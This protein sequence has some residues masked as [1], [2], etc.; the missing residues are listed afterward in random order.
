MLLI[1]LLGGALR[2]YGINW[3]QNSHYHPDERYI[4]MVTSDIR[5]PQ[6]INEF[7]DP[8]RSPMNPYWIARENRERAFAYGT[9]PVYMTRFV[10]YWVGVFVDKWWEGYDG[11]TLVGR[12]LSGLLDTAAIF[13]VFLLG[14]RI[15]NR[16]VGL[17]G[18][19]FYALTVL[20]IQHSHF[21]TTDITLNF[22]VLLTLL[23]AYNTSQNGSNSNT[24]MMGAAAGMAF[25]SKFSALPIL[26][27]LPMAA[28]LYERKKIT[29][30]NP[31][32]VTL[33][34]QFAYLNWGS[35]IS[36]LILAFGGFVLAY[37]I[38]APY[39]FL[40][41][42]GLM[43]NV[44]EQDKIVIRA[45]ADLPYTRQ[46]YETTP[47][48]YPIEQMLRWSMGVPLGVTALIGFVMCVVYALGRG[49]HSG[50]TSAG[51]ILMLSWM[52]PYFIITGRAYAKF[53]RYNLPLLPLFAI[54][55]AA[56]LITLGQ[57]LDKKYRAKAAPVAEPESAPIGEVTPAL[58][59][60]T[61]PASA[62]APPTAPKPRRHPMQYVAPALTAIVVVATAWWA[63]AFASIYSAP[64][65]ANQASK[66]INDNV[67]KNA[68]I[69]K[70]HWEEGIA[71][72]HG[73]QLPPAV[74]ELNLYDDDGPNK[75]ASL[76]NSLTRG[77]YIVFFSSR[78]YGTIPRIPDRYP[79]TKR[80][81]EML[82][83]G[84]LG[85][86]LV[87]F[88]E[89]FPSFFGVTMF[90]DTFARPGLPM[91]APLKAHRPTPFEINGGFADESFSAYDH[92]LVMVFKKTKPITPQMVTDWFGPYALKQPW[93]R[94]LAQIKR[95]PL[96]T[97]T[98]REL[99]MAGGTFSDLFDANSLAN[100]MPLLMWWLLLQVFSLSTLPI[101][102]H[103]A[104]GLPDRAYIFARV[105]GWL[106]V[107]W[108]IWFPVSFGVFNYTRPVALAALLLW[109]G[110]GALVFART[111]HHLLAWL[112]A[113][114][115][116]VALQEIVFSVGFLAFVWIRMNNPD[117]WHPARGGEKPMDFAYLLAAIKTST[118]PPYDPWFAGGF[119]NYY[120]YGQY[121]VGMMVKITGILPEV[122]YNL[123]VPMLFAMCL[124]GAWSL[125]YNLIASLRRDI[126]T[127]PNFQAPIVDRAAAWAGTLAA[128]LLAVFGNV[129]G[130]MRFFKRLVFIGGSPIPEQSYNAMSWGE[131]MGRFALGIYKAITEGQKALQIPTDWF[132][133]STRI[134][135]GSGSIQEFPYFTFLYADLH[136]HMIALPVSLL[137]LCWALILMARLGAN[138]S[139]NTPDADAAAENSQPPTLRQRLA[140]WLNELRAQA[141][142]LPLILLSGITLGSVWAINS[143]DFPIA[144]VIILGAAI[145]GWLHT[146]RQ[147]SQFIWAMLI[148]AAIVAWGYVAYLPFH[149]SFVQGYTGLETHQ[150][151]SP[152]LGW[153]TVDGVFLFI[154]VTWLLVWLIGRLRQNNTVTS[155]VAELN[156]LS[157]SP[158]LGI[159]SGSAVRVNVKSPKLRNASRA[160]ALLMANPERTRHILG[161]IATLEKEGNDATK[162][163]ATGDA[164]NS[165]ANAIPQSD[166]A[167]K[168][169]VSYAVVMFA[170]GVL[171]LLLRFA[172][173][174]F[175]PVAVIS[176]VL[177]FAFGIGALMQRTRAESFAMGAATVALGLTG[178]VEI[179]ALA[180]DIGRM[181]IVF[182][183]YFQAW[184]LMS[185]ASAVGLYVLSK[186]LPE[187]IRP[188]WGGVLA[189]LLILA[190]VYPFAAT[191]AK[192]NDRFDTKIAP[193]LNGAKYM[194]TAVYMDEAEF[195]TR[196]QQAELKLRDDWAAIEWVRANIS[197]S[198]VML[199]AVSGPPPHARLYSWGGRVAIYTGLPTILGWDHHQR[200]QRAGTP[201]IE[202]RTRDVFNI[203]TSPDVPQTQQ[204]L[205][206]YN[207]SY[208]YYGGVEKLHYPQAEAKLANLERSGLLS[209]I[210]DQ[211]GV[212]IYKINS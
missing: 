78:L 117:L 137:G 201:K 18:A 209:Q 170:A 182:K 71:G 184:A 211:N 139:A 111:R 127:D 53:L 59:P 206:Q 110:I 56:L 48:L 187:A 153:L 26:A 138:G 64:H 25:A 198:P 19:L 174:S 121:L 62:E 107:G 149:R 152:F 146:A 193:T 141:D 106:V 158:Q 41:T 55:A 61:A 172:S 39:S 46:Y 165:A 185:I 35:L 104:K 178:A 70:E 65:T 173:G 151:R 8:K 89:A 7:L 49:P 183:F 159:A 81:Y 2:L 144:V 167:P 28:L 91:P 77:D 128:L 208:I 200:Q 80:Y 131:T 38:F 51:A 140:A 4:S 47:Y 196:R 75:I 154:L 3:D 67:P 1:V 169:G 99:N 113:N 194:E 161:L 29:T 197:G 15:F 30:R 129:D 6:S 69:L 97:E 191:Y 23:F 45:E 9:L 16:R 93:N 83:N 96:L 189:V 126:N 199:E 22:F 125:A 123:A 212:K 135:P 179:W 130:G 60:S 58:E 94:Q 40:D 102:M 176:F 50:A 66:W 11:V 14:T 114:W 76:Q 204:L 177:A 124:A 207:V 115:R 105:L 34:A 210:Y 186:R 21:Y 108:L 72:L 166:A 36:T 86:E 202:E 84:E 42:N 119:I 52:L 118:L 12:A 74:P 150:E 79:V 133:A 156:Q 157:A 63:L 31:K 95:E 132:W 5:W 122:A 103:I 190:S 142:N 92:P 101:L 147:G 145:L 13:I 175:G 136:A 44:N 168:T 98:Q 88:S 162:T 32:L 109:L 112:R 37:F 192:I 33:S 160:L 54:M 203:Y 188:V 68:I 148:S 17:L 57:W 27:L 195:G 73:Y 180:G 171:A 90:E 164:T 85:Y 43:R 163:A 20:S 87:Y 120:Y 181:N 10:S 116:L 143:W 205:K 24:F 82:F 155:T 100:Q 134:Y